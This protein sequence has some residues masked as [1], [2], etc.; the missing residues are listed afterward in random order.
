MWELPNV[1]GKLS[2]TEA[3]ALATAW[4]TKPEA[5]IKS[6]ER[7]HVFTHIKWDMLCY[8]IECRE[9]PPCFTWVSRRQLADTYALP[10][11]FK[12]FLSTEDFS[13]IREDLN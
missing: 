5:I 3:V 9:Q 7:S 4:E 11:A 12:K 1:P 2:D 6:T 8:C 10:T 13:Q